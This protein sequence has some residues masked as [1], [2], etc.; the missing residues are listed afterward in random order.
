M[1]GYC[2]S[3]YNRLSFLDV[4]D[5]NATAFIAATGIT[6]PTIKTAI[7]TLCK[8]LKSG[9]IFDKMKAIYPFVGGTATTHKFNLVNP[10]DTDAAFRLAFN[11]GW[12]HSANGATPNG[13]NGYADTFLTPNLMAQNSAHLSIYNRTNSVGNFADMGGTSGT[14]D[15]QIISRFTSDRNYSTINTSIV[16]GFSSTSSDGQN[17]ISRIT[18]SNMNYF[19][20]NTK[21]I[22]T[23]ASIAPHAIKITIGARNQNNVTREYYSNRQI[24]FSTI[25]DGLTDT[26]A[27]NLYTA[28]QKFQTT[29]GRQV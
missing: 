29:L 25:G 12:T 20:N 11:G 13:T 4:P 1:Y 26:E 17:L 3:A 7:D 8:D 21:T 27:S 19:R 15:F 16:S 6:D 9:G 22:I 14:N 18:S 2:Y 23:R 24:A 5:S 28:V 10:A